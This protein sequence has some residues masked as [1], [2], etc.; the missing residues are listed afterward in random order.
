M[1]TT[2]Q[3]R[4]EHALAAC[5]SAPHAFTAE[6]EALK[7]LAQDYKKKLAR[8]QHEEQ[9][10]NIGIM[11][12]VKAGKSTFLNTL[13]FDGRPIL[14]EAATPKTANLTRIGYGEQHSLQVEY[15]SQ[16]EWQQIEEQARQASGSDSQKVATELLGMSAEKQIDFAAHWQKVARLENHTEVV[17][18]NDISEL[19]GL[20]NQFTGNDGQFTAL[21]K[22]TV[23]TLPDDALKGFEVV[24]T[25]GMNDP[26]QSRSQK[27]RDYM[28][29]CDVVFF[30]S[31]CSQFLD[32]ADI[33]LLGEQLPGKGVKRLV[34]VAGQYDSVILD[35]GYDRDSLAATEE[36]IQTRLLRIAQNKAQQLVAFQRDNGNE[37]RAAIL[38]RLASPVFASTFAWGFAH[39]PQAK[40][41]QSM[42]HTFGGLEAMAEDCWPAPFSQ[43][44]WE[45]IAN[46]AP[47]QAEWQ[48]AR[49][50]RLPLL[51]QQREGF[52]RES[53]G[54]LNEIVARLRGRIT[55]RITS[56]E[57]QDLQSLRQ[58]QAQCRKRLEGIA[59]ELRTIIGDTLHRARTETLR[60]SG[61]LSDDIARFRQ[62]QA[63]TGYQQER[64]SY[65]VSDS[66][67]Y[68][69]WSWGSTRTEYGTT[70]VAY[71][72][73]NAQD[74][75]EQL[76]QYSRA[77]ASQI[78]QHFN[79]LIEPAALKSTL[80]QALVHHLNTDSEQFDPALFRGA[81]ESAIYALDLPE[82]VLKADESQMM[83]PFQGEIKS[84]EDKQK[85]Q[86]ALDKAL[87]AMFDKLAKQLDAGAKSIFDQ[88]ETLKSGLQETLSQSL[89]QEFNEIEQGLARKESEMAAYR[90]L[91]DQLSR[92]NK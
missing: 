53:E 8:W 17:L 91:L 74:A 4:I 31:R 65:Q 19:Q 36:N 29:N 62:L 41:S 60:V 40:W 68:K 58:Q 6:L 28:A 63:H 32:D 39:W 90:A 88:L 47:L 37:A 52:T 89:Q 77:C 1:T 85:L 57:T 50:D 75:I 70:S 14:P 30:L 76:R 5:T 3:Q 23:L 20:L 22:S 81:L 82:L 24:D 18:A 33:R 27:T 12:Q 61:R 48:Q 49:A 7:T 55:D 71:Q 80:R 78:R 79:Q 73:F 92:D 9:T 34:L 11:G 2:L 51:A 35:D 26:V 54:Q 16:Q 38:E 46:F 66:T 42:L 15:Y 86:Q 64:Y 69:P 43:Q 13:L 83:I 44:D 45:R 21:V 59:A 72:Y 87:G 84:S 56:L 10:L 25:P 67:W